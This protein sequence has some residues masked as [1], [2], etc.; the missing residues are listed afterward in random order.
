[1]KKLELVVKHCN[2][3]LRLKPDFQ[4]IRINLANVLFRLGRVEE[5]IETAEEAIKLA[6]TMGDK[7][8]AE[9]VRKQLQQYKTKK[10]SHQQ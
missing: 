9:E 1:M 4:E 3:I 10:A 6:E 8:T 7:E 5:A 2:E